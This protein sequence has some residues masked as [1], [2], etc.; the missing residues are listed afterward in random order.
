MSKPSK[1]KKNRV[2]KLTEAEYTAYLLSLRELTEGENPVLNTDTDT[3]KNAAGL[4]KKE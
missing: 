1:H 3:P 2:P 4:I